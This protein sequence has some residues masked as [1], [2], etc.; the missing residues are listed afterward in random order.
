MKDFQTIESLQ[1]GIL[2]N[3]CSAQREYCYAYDLPQG[4][5]LI[6]DRDYAWDMDEFY[7]NCDA[8]FIVDAS[9][10]IISVIAPAYAVDANGDPINTNYRIEGDSLIQVIDFDSASAF[11]I[12]A[13]SS[14]HPNKY[15]EMRFT[16]SQATVMR[17]SY[18]GTPLASFISN[19]ASV[20]AM[21]SGYLAGSF[22][23]AMLSSIL[24]GLG[25]VWT[26]V[27]FAGHLSCTYSNS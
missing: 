8:V 20:C 17:N 5:R 6:L 1:T 16:K 26:L 9:G 24:G 18:T 21:V 2:V 10:E 27:S 19:G 23:Y 4:Y 25:S 3:D 15:T 13:Y 7:V 12:I 14:D 22:N 11:P